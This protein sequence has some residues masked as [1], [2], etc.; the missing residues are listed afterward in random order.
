MVCF[1]WIQLTKK[2]DFILSITILM[3]YVFA[4]LGILNKTCGCSFPLKKWTLVITWHLRKLRFYRILK[5]GGQKRGV[6]WNIDQTFYRTVAILLV[7]VFAFSTTSARIDETSN[8]D[9]I[10][11]LKLHLAWTDFFNNTGNFVAFRVKT[12]RKQMKTES[13]SSRNLKKT[14]I[15]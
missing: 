12:L 9:S 10:T 3:K 7:T 6:A 4:N 8:S 1:S 14:H 15:F 11:Q 2:C 5:M 13:L